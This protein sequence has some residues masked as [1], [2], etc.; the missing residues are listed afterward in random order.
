MVTAPRG[1]L[2][3]DRKPGI[4]LVHND[5]RIARGIPIVVQ[6][7]AERLGFKVVPGEFPIGREYE[8]GLGDPIAEIAG[9]V[10][11]A[12]PGPVPGKRLWPCRHRGRWP[13]QGNVP[14]GLHSLPGFAVEAA[15]MGGKRRGLG[16]PPRMRN[17]AHEIVAG[18]GEYGEGRFAKLVLRGFRRDLIGLGYQAAIPIAGWRTFHQAIAEGAAEAYQDR[19]EWN[20]PECRS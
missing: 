6:L 16:A 4:G 14:R 17:H 13:V 10:I 20:R 7:H 1:H 18:H 3:A 5:I 12:A 19:L 15:D 2:A 8:V 11:M 9:I